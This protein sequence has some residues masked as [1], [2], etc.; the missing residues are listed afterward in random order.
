MINYKYIIRDENFTEDFFDEIKEM[1]FKHGMSYIRKYR[2]NGIRYGSDIDV[3]YTKAGDTNE[4]AFSLRGGGTFVGGKESVRLYECVDSYIKGY[5]RGS[6]LKQ[7][8]I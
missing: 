8:G 3:F 1:C 6:K 7:L 4:S 5:L 2:I